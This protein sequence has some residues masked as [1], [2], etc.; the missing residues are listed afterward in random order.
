[1]STAKSETGQS[2]PPPTLLLNNNHKPLSRVSS[3]PKDAPQ[4]PIPP[5]LTSTSLVEESGFLNDL[6][7][8]TLQDDG[9]PNN[10]D[11]NTEGISRLKRN[12]GRLVYLL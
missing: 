10:D 12:R 3:P 2:D 6:A 5:L 9:F 11:H 8:M 4:R 1:M 7:D